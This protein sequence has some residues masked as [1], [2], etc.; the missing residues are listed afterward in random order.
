VSGEAEV[1]RALASVRERVEKAARRAGRDPAEMVLVGVA[2]GQPIGRVVAALRAGL[3]DVGESYVQ[4]ARATLAET[5][6]LLEAEPGLRP[7]WHL[8][9]RLQRNK[10]R[11]AVLL[12]DVIHSL[13]RPELARELDRHAARAGRRL[14][15]LL[16]VNLSGEPRKGGVPPEQAPGL[17]AAC[18]PLEHL[19]VVGLMTIP[20]PSSDAEASRPAFA[21]LRRLRDR[22]RPAA[23][24]SDLRELSMGMSGDYEV[25]IE[26]GATFVRVGAA[27]FGPR[28]D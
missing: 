7:R 12:F 18:L 11:D 10:A 2:K 17:L 20:A 1:G 28:E 19:R 25:A 14:D 5:G 26:E 3:R 9:G 16:Q 22:M 4:E 23:G 13:D 8:V 24:G 21:E 15:V 6:R 27:I